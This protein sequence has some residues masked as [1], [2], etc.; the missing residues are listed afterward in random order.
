[1]DLAI[2][3]LTRCLQGPNWVSAEEMSE[4]LG[5]SLFDSK[6]WLTHTCKSS[7][8]IRCSRLLAF[9]SWI[10]IDK[11]KKSIPATTWPWLDRQA[12]FFS[13]AGE[14]YEYA[15][16]VHFLHVVAAKSEEFHARGY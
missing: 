11:A 13:Q 9:V 16:Y 15:K 7:L 12:V 14:H 1:M 5:W 8:G 6:V 10:P 3:V 4:L 2:L